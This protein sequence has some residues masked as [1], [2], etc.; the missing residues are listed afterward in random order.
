MTNAKHPRPDHFLLLMDDSEASEKALRYLADL[1]RTVGDGEIAVTLLHALDMPPRLVEHGGAESPSEERERES[2]LATE[3]KRWI[4]ESTRKAEPLFNRARDLLGPAGV[5]DDR[6]DQ[7]I[8]AE[9]SDEL[10]RET[11]R[12]AKERSCGTVVVG[13][14]SLPWY[15]DV[16]HRHLADELIERGEGF[17]ILVLP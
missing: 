14:S 4:D 15:R 17:A 12:V 7:R 3:R 10:A 5:R 11:L 8:A 6:I 13:R 9:V 2:D 16:V 1:A